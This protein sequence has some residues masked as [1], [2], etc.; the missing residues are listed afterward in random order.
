MG[1]VIFD[2]QFQSNYKTVF[3][4]QKQF[5]HMWKTLYSLFR[6]LPNEQ[7]MYRAIAS[8]GTLLLNLGEISSEKSVELTSNQRP[9]VSEDISKLSLHDQ[10][11]VKNSKGPAREKEEYFCKENLSS[12]D[13]IHQQ[14]VCKALADAAT[15]IVTTIHDNDK[16]NV[17]C[18]PIANDEGHFSGS[19]IIA[20]ADESESQTTSDL[21]SK[22]LNFSQTN[23]DTSHKI[24]SCENSTP[25]SL[26]RDDFG[27]GCV[28]NV[29]HRSRSNSMRRRSSGN[30]DPYWCIT[31]KQFFASIHTEPLLVE[32]FEKQINIEEIITTVKTEGLGDFLRNPRRSKS[33]E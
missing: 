2:S 19:H 21:S 5:I 33:L 9:C 22:M 15:D 29:S 17:E 23:T 7:D 18:I 26:K 8:V 32:Y 3:I 14:R 24:N 27:K 4:F 31:F 12:E 25:D 28:E 6:D 20:L 11:K 30:V 16:M 10:D 1:I 13:D